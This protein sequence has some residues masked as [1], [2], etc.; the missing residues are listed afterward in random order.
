VII[1]VTYIL[2][3]IGCVQIIRTINKKFNTSTLFA[4]LLIFLICIGDLVMLTP[5]APR[6]SYRDNYVVEWREACDF[7]STRWQDGDYIITT[8]GDPVEFYLGRANYTLFGE[9]D[10]TT[11]LIWRKDIAEN[12]TVWLI[13]DH[14]R[15]YKSLQS[16]QR[17][18][19][20]RNFE[21]VWES[22][23]NY[24][25]KSSIFE[26]VWK[27][28]CDVITSEYMEGDIILTTDQNAIRD[29]LQW[30]V[31]EDWD[32]IIAEYNTTFRDAIWRN[33]VPANVTVWFVADKDKFF[34][35][36]EYWQRDWLLRNFVIYWESRHTYL[37]KNES[38]L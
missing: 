6:K 31:Y 20:W 14:G 11:R 12:S 1:P 23:H 4:V 8:V 25:F 35:S 21:L 15:F 18:W 10:E 34:N 37:F 22:K 33:G 3:A 38:N 28:A 32:C 7:V 2:A 29:Y 36:F 5:A 24:V 17:D 9:W 26:K 30:P 16:W 19:I 27:D 13:V